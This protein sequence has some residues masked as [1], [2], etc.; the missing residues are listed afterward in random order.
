MTKKRE[1][2][3]ALVDEGLTHAEIG[4]LLGV[5]PQAI[6]WRLCSPVK[7]PGS[8]HAK[9]IERRAQ[10]L[11][12][13]EKECRTCSKVLPISEYHKFFKDGEFDRYAH[14]CNKCHSKEVTERNKKLCR[15]KD[16][17]WYKKRLETQ[18]RAYYRMM[19]RAKHDPAL[20][21]K[22][23]EKSIRRARV[24]K[25][26][27]YTT[28]YYQMKKAQRLAFVEQQANSPKIRAILE[29]MRGL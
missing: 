12:L 6:S 29:K 14:I 4:R 7:G 2:Y 11:Q 16:S 3:K 28:R 15:D 8:R 13:K 5:T 26:S 10:L 22:L 17:E 25:E 20:R 27:G 19:E 18:K 24:A 23:K 21:A 9:V 1:F